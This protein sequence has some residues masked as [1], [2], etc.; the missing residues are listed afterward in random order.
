MNTSLTYATWPKVCGH[1]KIMW[2][3][4][5]KVVLEAETSETH[6]SKHGKRNL[7]SLLY[8][9]VIWVDPS[10]NARLEGVLIHFIVSMLLL[11]HNYDQSILQKAN[12]TNDMVEW[13]HYWLMTFSICLQKQFKKGFV[14]G[15]TSDINNTVTL[16]GLGAAEI[17]ML[18]KLNW[19]TALH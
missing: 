9:L 18:H 15:C 16:K 17:S 14:M 19:E 10:F 2:L 8:F 12:H 6:I 7:K 13:I 5:K 4:N 3:L 1:P 11:H